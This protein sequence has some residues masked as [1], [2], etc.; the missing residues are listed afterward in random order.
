MGVCRDTA[1]PW[2]PPFWG[3]SWENERGAAVPALLRATG[4]SGGNT[5]GLDQPFAVSAAIKVLLFLRN[6]Y[7]C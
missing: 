6:G 5:Q 7:F 1:R 3:R 4:K 2:K